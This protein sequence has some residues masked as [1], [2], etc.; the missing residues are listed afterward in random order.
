[1]AGWRWRNDQ[2]PPL[3]FCHATGFCASA[4]KQMLGRLSASFDIYALDMR[5]HGRTDLPANP[6][7]LKSWRIYARDIASFLDQQ[8]REQWTLA[9]H[10]MGA[11]T[12]TMAARGRDDIA[13]VKLIE[14]VAMPQLLN[15]VAAT[16]VW[17]L[18]SSRLSLVQKAASRRA[19]W[20]ARSDVVASYSKKAL[21]R[22]W[23]AGALSD[24]LEDGLSETD[25]GVVLSCTPEWEAATFAAHANNFWGAVAHS[26]AP[27][28][29]F[30]ANSTT[31]TVIEIARTR[32]LKTGAALKTVDGVSHLAPMEKPGLAAD[33]VASST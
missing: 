33:F 3:M 12:A 1:M 18:I 32:F 29:V 15:F 11:V 17:P 9:G 16:P 10:S 27:I 14:P 23:S 30:A 21:F 25:D 24:Y 26:P 5:G 19:H 28:A 20:S 4:Y 31:S 8:N 6:R 2:K 7:K 22:E 13:A